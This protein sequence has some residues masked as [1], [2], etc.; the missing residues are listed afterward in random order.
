MNTVNIQGYSP[1][2]LSRNPALSSSG[3]LSQKWHLCTY[4]QFTKCTHTHFQNFFFFFTKNYL[5]K[6]QYSSTPSPQV[7]LYANFSFPQGVLYLHHIYLNTTEKHPQT[8]ALLTNNC[9]HGYCPNVFKN[10]GV[11]IIYATIFL[12]KTFPIL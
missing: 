10:L 4:K 2:I 7:C 5:Q 11:F 1:G 6:P 12:C 3:V 8:Q 9:T